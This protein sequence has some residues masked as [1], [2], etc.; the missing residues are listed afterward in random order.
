M[1]SLFGANFNDSLDNVVG[2]S[3]ANALAGVAITANT[4]TTTQGKWQFQASGTTTWTDIGT[5]L[6]D[7][8][9]LFLAANTSIRFLPSANYNGTPGAL[10]VRLVDNSGTPPTNA[11]NINVATNGGITA[12]S[13][14]TVSLGTSITS[15]NDAPTGTNATI[16]VTQNGSKTFAAAD[17]GFSDTSD[18]PADAFSNVIITTLPVNGTLKLNGTTVTVNQVIPVG[19]LSTLVYTPA[20]GA[21]GNSYATIGFKVQDSGGT[22]NGGVDIS[23]SAYNYTITVSAVTTGNYFFKTS[24]PTTAVTSFTL[25]EVNNNQ[26]GFYYNGGATLPSFTATVTKGTL[27]STTASS[28][29]QFLTGATAPDATGGMLYYGDGSGTGGAGGFRSGTGVSGAGDADNFVGT[30]FNDVIF[31]DGSGGGEGVSAGSGGSTGLAGRGGGGNDTLVGNAGNDII[32]GDGFAGTDITFTGSA[33]GVSGGMGGYGGGGAAGAI[34]NTSALVASIGGGAGGFGP[35]ISSALPAPSSP[36]YKGQ[37]NTVGVATSTNPYSQA[38]VNYFATPGAGVTADGNSSSPSAT[39]VSAMLSKS[40]YEKVLSDISKTNSTDDRVFTQVMGTGNDSINAGAGND[41]VMGGYGNDTLIGGTGDDVMWGRGGGDHIVNLAVTNGSTTTTETTDVYF[42]DGLKT[43]E[44]VTVG[45]LTLTASSA[46]TAAQITSA[47]TGLAAGA[48]NGNTVI[49]ASYTASGSL[50]GW[51][52]GQPTIIGG[53]TAIT[54][55]STTLNTDVTNLTASYK[56]LD[57]DI[58]KWNS[59]DAGAAGAVDIIKDFSAWNGTSGDKLDILSLLTG[60]TSGTSILSQW[61][62]VTTGQTAPGSS[63]GNST[64]L[65]IDI[66]GAATGTVSQT[67]WLEGVTLGTNVDTLKTTGVLIA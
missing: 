34:S 16:N 21:I 67:I 43:G 3:S 53:N 10:T 25:T 29:T 12:Y 47:Y 24:A 40:V 50:T 6:S 62:T 28:S 35:N 11:T 65:V 30:T 33:N 44:S 57:N 52:S 17:F 4:A 39:S 49:G 15:V 64:R 32:F 14:A 1:S 38:N 8:S 59:G 19:S 26:I 41:W 55:I 60:Y 27:I 20:I 31:G 18:S 61:V 5:S 2:G 45:G 48:T 56:L 23:T 9:A 22:T 51:S 58:F 66:N 46:M 37:S 13:S 42:T 63:T 54:F 7:A 36:I